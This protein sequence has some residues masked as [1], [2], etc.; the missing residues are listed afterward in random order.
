M[1]DSI[2]TFLSMGGYAA[3][4]WPAFGVALVVLGGLLITSL[5]TLRANQTALAALQAAGGDRRHAH[6]NEARDE[7]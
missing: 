3:F 4:V 1:A 2:S 6:G 7:T 5:R